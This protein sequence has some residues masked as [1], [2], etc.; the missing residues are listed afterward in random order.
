MS[1]PTKVLIAIAL[2]GILAI[3]AALGYA[4][5]RSRPAVTDYMLAAGLVNGGFE[6]A[7]SQ[8]PGISEWIVPAG[9][10]PYAL[11]GNPPAEHE[12]GPLA[13]PEFKELNTTIDAN[14]VH[15][16]FKSA[17]WF[18]FYKV[19]QGGLYQRVPV[20]KGQYYQFEVWVQ[21][22]CSN[23]D[24]PRVSDQEMY[25][26]LGIDPDGQT[27]ARRK[28]VV[29]ST[30]KPIGTE[31]RR[32]VTPPVRA[33][34]NYITVYIETW[35]KYRIKHADAYVDDATLYL[36]DLGT[37]CATPEPCP[38][39]PTPGPCNDNATLEQFRSIIREELR[40]IEIDIR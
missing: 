14:R 40:A 35:N 19:H 3:A 20:V 2:V 24:E 9:W 25:A 1:K 31:Y 12:Q 13:R 26:S 15:S 32:I 21:A 39:C 5:S 16:G 37:G 34:E 4:I 38:A 29:W 18:T 7:F 23:S 33:R 22:W 30:W 28:G 27:D 10:T 11:E 17:A 8:W 6:G 36:L